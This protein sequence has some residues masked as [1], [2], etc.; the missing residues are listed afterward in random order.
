MGWVVLVIGVGL[1][2]AAHLF[3]RIDPAKRAAMGD[4]GKGYVALAL[5]G[6][7]VL[8]VIGFKM[9][10]FVNLWFPPSFFTHINNLLV[11]V[12]I[13]MMSPAPKRGRLLNGMRH[14]MLTGFALW[15]FAHLLVNGDLAAIVL[16]GGLLAWA[17]V[18][19]RVLTAAE[20]AW[21]PPAPGTYGKDAMFFAASIVL[22]AI[23]GYIHGLVGPSPFGS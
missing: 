18:E 10:P 11:L 23:I 13:Y 14:P 16:F 19:M 1:W 6:S 7:I 15:A 21:T 8:M 5:V 12:A 20:P 3:K 17:L 2:W 9:T 4:K 22:L